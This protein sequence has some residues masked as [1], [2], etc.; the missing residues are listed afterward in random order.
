MKD[1]L[2]HAVSFKN[3][4]G[5]GYGSIE[6]GLEVAAYRSK[7]I[8]YWMKRIGCEWCEAATRAHKDVIAKY[9]EAV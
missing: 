1:L 2:D 4:K 9:G 3:G 6:L 5:F 7:R 8:R